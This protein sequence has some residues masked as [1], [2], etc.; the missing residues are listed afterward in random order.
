MEEELEIPLKANIIF[1]LEQLNNQK[2][3]APLKG[4]CGVKIILEV[5]KKRYLE[6][7]ESADNLLEGLDRI[8]KKSRMEITSVKNIK[9][10]SSLFPKKSNRVDKFCKTSYTSCRIVKSIEK[11]IKFC[12]NFN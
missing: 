5:N 4:R 6:K 12:L 11:A 9:T 10:V 7:V 1:L 2:T 3:D 8:L